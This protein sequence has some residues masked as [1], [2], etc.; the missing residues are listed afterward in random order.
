M[1]PLRQ[2][3]LNELQRR[4]YA[5][6]TIRSYL[7]AVEQ[8]AEYFHRSP[9]L[10]GP[11]HLRHY[12]LYLLQEKKLEPAT[13][14]VRISALRFLY[15]RTL[16]RRD[17]AFDD[18]LF[19]KTPYKLPTVLSQC[20]HSRSRSSSDRVLALHPHVDCFR[21]ARN[22]GVARKR[23]EVTCPVTRFI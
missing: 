2:R 14:E 20:T 15:K 19:P 3:M 13:V 4:N 1:I 23:T 18:L 22:P 7:G 16:K 5:P 11:A 21:I 8:F 6:S 9:E 17:L 12:Q 10:L